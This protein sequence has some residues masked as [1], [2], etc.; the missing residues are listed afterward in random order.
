MY[1]EKGAP[2]QRRID[3]YRSIQ[4]RLP[5]DF[6]ELQ[7]TQFAARGY[8]SGVRAAPARTFRCLSDEGHSWLDFRLVM[9]NRGA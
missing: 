3:R 5:M 8:C 6:L 1:A 9:R 7:P 4:Q 2:N